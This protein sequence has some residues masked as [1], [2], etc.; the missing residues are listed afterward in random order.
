MPPRVTLGR[1][2]GKLFRSGRVAIISLK[3]IAFSETVTSL[4]NAGVTG[5]SP[6]G[7]TINHRLVL[8]GACAIS[9]AVPI[10]TPV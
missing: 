4:R 6:V 8:P 3:E 10:C 2:W 5:S 1:C 9:G 7:G